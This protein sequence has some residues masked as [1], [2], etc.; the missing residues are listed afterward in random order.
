MNLF[1][2]KFQSLNIPLVEPPQKN[3]FS[4]ETTTGSLVL[5]GILDYETYKTY[6]VTVQVTDQTSFLKQTV[7]ISLEDVNDNRPRCPSSAY[8]I[9]VPE[10]SPNHFLIKNLSDCSDADGTSS[11]NSFS[12]SINGGDDIPNKFSIYDMS[13]SFNL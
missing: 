9:N 13:V 2:A 10:N 5:S 11:H 8:S 7:I 3:L 12:I 6:N 1:R 4:I